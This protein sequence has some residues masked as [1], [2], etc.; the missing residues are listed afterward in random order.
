[1]S[2]V[3]RFE[4]NVNEA[5]FKGDTFYNMRKDDVFLVEFETVE[6]ILCQGKR[7]RHL[8]KT[9]QPGHYLTIEGANISDG[10][11]LVVRKGGESCGQ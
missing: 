5:S 6:N 4:D 9:V 7:M 2:V 8:M 3:Y 1:M 11:P 10:N